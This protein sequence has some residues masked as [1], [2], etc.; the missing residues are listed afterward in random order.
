M[1]YKAVL[2][3][4]AHTMKK[5]KNFDV[6]FYKTWHKNPEDYSKK[7]GLMNM[8]FKKIKKG[9]AILVANFDKNG[10]KGYIGGNVFMEITIA[11]YLKKPIFI[12]YDIEKSSSIKE[13]V[14]AVKSIFLKGN[15]SGLLSSQSSLLL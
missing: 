2:P 6:S 10:V 12:L 9:D 4:T 3:K 14:F 5:N 11:Y 8:H 7:R 13:E 1:G 15:L